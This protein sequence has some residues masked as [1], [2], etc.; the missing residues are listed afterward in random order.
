MEEVGGGGLEER[1]AGEGDGVEEVGGGPT[2]AGAQE[3]ADGSRRERDQ[4]LG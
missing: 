4:F 3:F 1:G 2:T